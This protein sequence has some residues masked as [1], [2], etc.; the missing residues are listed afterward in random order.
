MTEIREWSGSPWRKAPDEF[1]VDDQTGELV[2][3]TTCVRLPPSAKRLTAA[4]ARELAARRA[5]D[6]GSSPPTIC[7]E[8]AYGTTTRL[9]FQIKVF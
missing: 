6:V 1:W 4:Q 8:T 5:A 9:S 7:Q 2:E 3:T